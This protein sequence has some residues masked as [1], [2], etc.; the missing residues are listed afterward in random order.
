MSKLLG[1]FLAAGL[2]YCSS[3]QAEQKWITIGMVDN[4]DMIELKKLSAK[5]EAAM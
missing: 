1:L 4:P 3:V 5:F 2:F